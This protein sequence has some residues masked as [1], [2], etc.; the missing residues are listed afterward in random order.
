[1]T[2]VDAGVNVFA[3]PQLQGLSDRETQVTIELLTRLAVTAPRNRL[4]A[5]YYEG[6]QRV[7]D[8]GISIP[9]SLRN[10]ETVVGWP[11]T[12]V[13]VLEEQ[14]DLEGFGFPGSDDLGVSDIFKAN[15]LATESGLGHL[16]ALIYGVTYIAVGTGFDGEPDPLITVESPMHTTAYYDPRARRVGAALTQVWDDQSGTPRR[17]VLY[18]PD[19]T[20]TADRPGS[21]GA[22]YDPVNGTLNLAS[23]VIVN[24]DQHRL[25]RVPM[26]RLVNRPRSSDV[27]GRSEI[28]R[29]VRALTDNAVRTV[30]GMEVAREFYSAPQ[31]YVLGASEEAF[32]DSAGNAIPAWQSYLGRMLALSPELD[33]ESGTAM[34][35]QVGQFA[36]GTM[37]PYGDQVRLLSQLLAAEA[38][39]PATF[40]GFVTENP[41]SA[42]A[43]NAAKARLIKRAERRQTQFGAGW[44]DAAELALL[45]RDAQPAPDG[46]F[47]KW[48]DP[49]T[50][51]RA[52]ATDAAVKL[53]QAGV[54]PP[55]DDVTYELIGMTVDQRS[56]LAAGQTQGMSPDDLA[57]QMAASIGL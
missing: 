29:A 33:E 45:V 3:F 27:N 51:T 1:M 15:H 10:V 35:L 4:K 49:A 32:V 26:T 43:I 17:I 23:W 44:V 37:S 25:A 31:R 48:T 5:A 12:T 54:L 57:T 6:K 36:A 40:L 56:R 9:P 42:D 50:S 19:E 11:G 18:L 14:L 30:L 20:I 52:A 7:R 38:G 39:I 41:A 53:V 8:L 55:H 47:A 24:R 28:T 46:L 22:G 16:D 2:F 21:D 34:P 13:D